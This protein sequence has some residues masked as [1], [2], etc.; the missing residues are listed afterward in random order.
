MKQ[1]CEK[2]I[3]TI[4]KAKEFFA[5]ELEIRS[6][7]LADIYEDMKLWEQKDIFVEA[8]YITKIRY[9]IEVCECMLELWQQRLEDA[10]DEEI[11]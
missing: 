8:E 3:E 11:E 10:E 6:N 2:L 5:D 4:T 7:I 9:A 1:H